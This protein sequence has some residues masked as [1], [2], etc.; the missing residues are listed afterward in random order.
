MAVMK[1]ILLTAVMLVLAVVGSAQRS[2]PP[3]CPAIQ[4]FAATSEVIVGE[5]VTFHASVT[6]GDL[7]LSQVSYYWHIDGGKIT[8]GDNITQAIVVE[9]ASVKAPG[10][11]IAT[12][13]IGGIEPC[14]RA[15]SEQVTIKPKSKN[16]SR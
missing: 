3:D 9:T 6:G 1:T 7:D 15:A 2:K 5:T 4:V 12:V 13:E 16:S 8:G 10:A 14:C 11:I